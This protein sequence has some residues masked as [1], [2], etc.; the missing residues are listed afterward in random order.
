MLVFYVCFDFYHQIY[1]GFVTDV[2]CLILICISLW[3]LKKHG[4]Q[5]WQI[6][7]TLL[8]GVCVFGPLFVLDSFG[9]TGIYWL[10]ALPMIVFMLGGTR[11]GLWWGGVYFTALILSMLLAY[12]GLLELAYSWSEVLFMF[13]VTVFTA[14]IAYFFTRFLEQADLDNQKY[15]QQLKAA[16]EAKSNFLSVMSHELRTPLH[17]MIGMQELLMKDC[18]HFSVEQQECLQLS[19]QS[20]KVLKSLLH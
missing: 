6:H 4:L 8:G 19:L 13:L 5:A 17:G 14:L 18:K 2:I 9:D 7:I 10:P 20:S 1:W 11:T 16:S 12:M 15:Q 3:S